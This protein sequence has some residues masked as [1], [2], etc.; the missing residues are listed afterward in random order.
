MKS[1][2]KESTLILSTVFK[3]YRYDVKRF[4]SPLLFAVLMIITF[5][6]SKGN[7]PLEFNPSTMIS[8]VYVTLIFTLQLSVLRTFSATVSAYKRFAE[9]SDIPIFVLCSITSF[10]KA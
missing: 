3:T 6:F 1:L 2:K 10:P 8:E 5:S 4:L 7:G 9:S